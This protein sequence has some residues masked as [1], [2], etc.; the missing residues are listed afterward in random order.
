MIC[1]YDLD[2]NLLMTFDTYRE[3]AEA[4]GTSIGSLKTHVCNQRK[5][6]VSRKRYKG[7]WVQL[8]RYNDEDLEES[9]ED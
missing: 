2:G 9:V 3:C 1:V 4:F 5:G 7:E 6:K 8:I